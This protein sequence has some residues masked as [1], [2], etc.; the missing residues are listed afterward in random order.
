MSGS[1]IMIWFIVLIFILD[2]LVLFVYSLNLIFLIILS[3]KNRESLI[4][5]DKKLNNYPFVT[6]QLPLFNE[7]Y[8]VERIISGTAALDYPKE[9]MEIQ[10]LDD[11][12]DET[13]LLSGE[14]VASYRRQGY[15]ISLIHRTM[16]TGFKGG[17]LRGGLMSARGEFI[18]I[19]DADFI[20]ESDMLLKVLPLFM[21]NQRLGM[22]QTRWG[23]LN[24]SFS[25][26]TKAQ[27]IIIDSHF[28]VEQSARSA[29][30]L[31][32]NFNGTSGIWRK[33][34]ILDAGN[35]EDD[36]LT[37]DC[38]LSFRA[39]LKHWEFKYIDNI[40]T[41]AELPVYLHSYKS[42]Q[43]RWAK[44]SIQT[45]KK[46]GAGIF[47]ASVPLFKKI[48]AFIHLTYYSVHPFLL[49]NILLIIPLLMF[50]QLSETFEAFFG[51]SAAV[52][53]FAA[54]IPF[55]LFIN[56]IIVIKDNWIKRLTWIPYSLLFG[57]GLGVNNSI[58]I[59]QALLGK[60]SGFIRTP[61]TGTKEKS[62]KWE[63]NNYIPKNKFPLYTLFELFFC[64][65]S[66]FGIFLAI[67]EHKYFIIPF[68][69][70][71]CLAFGTVFFLGIIQNLSHLKNA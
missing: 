25:P 21:E 53:S 31:F 39:A 51:G 65:Y 18:A 49:L 57:T 68:L 54:F 50:R 46:L 43:F 22:V 33:T 64:L 16:R 17:A 15:N 1:F 44:G 10:V 59:F 42:Q 56:T 38:D 13:L 70:I 28:I 11:S 6:I 7:Q 26:L 14:L 29:H 19:F 66:G 4:V 40:V 60:K 9:R 41:R 62:K 37:E 55:I 3:K 32:F 67:R 45:I 58:A 61:K 23:H 52:I 8:V 20:P 36:T 27:S 30:N 69:L 12:T 5:T 47:A 34:C 71:Y 63:K 2:T 24:P 48:E 35:W